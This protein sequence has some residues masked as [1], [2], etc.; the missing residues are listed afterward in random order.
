MEEFYDERMGGRQ[1]I[2]MEG[3]MNQSSKRRDMG[4]SFSGLVYLREIED[5][6]L[7]RLT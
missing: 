7:S 5:W 1:C 2:I 6:P 3:V 4:G